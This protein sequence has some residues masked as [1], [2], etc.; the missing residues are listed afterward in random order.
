[1][2]LFYAMGA[3]TLALILFFVL[4]LALIGLYGQFVWTFTHWDLASIQSETVK[5]WVHFAMIMVFGIGVIVGI[6]FFGGYAWSHLKNRRMV[7]AATRAR[8]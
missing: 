3:G 2:V 8:R 7:N 4:A 6:W 1:M 5:P